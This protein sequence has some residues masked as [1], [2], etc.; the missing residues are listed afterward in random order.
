MTSLAQVVPL[1]ASYKRRVWLAVTALVAFM[2]LYFFLAGWFLYTAYRVLIVADA[3]TFSGLAV[4]VG[5]LFLA[6]FMLKPLFF[7]KRGTLDD[8]LEVTA[9]DQP[10]LFAFLHALADSAEAPRPHRVF[11]SGRVN[12]DHLTVDRGRNQRLVTAC[13]PGLRHC[14]AAP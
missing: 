10:R 11:L 12:L 9:R 7:V 14:G 6:V 2:L 5:A 4:G 13:L 1:S 3:F 8:M